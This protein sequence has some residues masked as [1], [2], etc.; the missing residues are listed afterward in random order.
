MT[1]IQPHTV[2]Q[3]LSDG[4]SAS[5]LAIA[6]TSTPAQSTNPLIQLRAL[7]QA[8]RADVMDKLNIRVLRI[9]YQPEDKA[10]D[11]GEASAMGK[12]PVGGLSYRLLIHG[13]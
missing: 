13:I 7:E 8:F 10:V 1:A 12:H 6:E 5:S 2:S 3:N 11:S 4:T 9:E